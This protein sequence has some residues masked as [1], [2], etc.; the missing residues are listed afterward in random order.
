M[1]GTSAVVTVVLASALGI[2]WQP[3]RVDAAVPASTSAPAHPQHPIRLSLEPRTEGSRLTL[4]VR[5]ERSSL[6]AAL[7]AHLDL[8]LPP[9]VG[10]VRGQTSVTVP[11]SAS[12]THVV[13]LSVEGVP[14]EDIVAVVDLR[15]E[16]RTAHGEARHRFGREARSL[17]DP[18]R[19]PNT[20]VR[21][22]GSLGTRIR[23][24]PVP[25]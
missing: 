18:V 7:P 1:V 3:P 2:A 11:A 12:W 16:G 5:L 17:V 24:A 21:G 8:R 19:L 10:V 13:E 25:R 6:Y 4:G 23:V 20:P 15:G 22:G 14:S 9:G